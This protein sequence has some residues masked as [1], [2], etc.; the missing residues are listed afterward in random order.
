M[1]RIHVRP[2]KRVKG[3]SRRRIG[4]I[5]IE[6]WGLSPKDFALGVVIHDSNKGLVVKRFDNPDT[7]RDYIFSRTCRGIRFYGHNVQYDLLG[8]MDNPLTFFDKVLFS[9]SQFIMGVKKVTEKDNVTVVDSGNLFKTSLRNIGQS[10]GY[11]KLDTP[12]DFIT[13]KKRKITEQDYLY[14]ERDCGIVYEVVKNFQKWIFREYGCNLGLTIA[15]TALRAFLTRYGIDH[16]VDDKVNDIYRKSYYGGRTEA[17]ILGKTNEALNYY[18]VNSLY[19]YVYRNIRFPD[20]SN[21]RYTSG[22]DNLLRLLKDNTIEGVAHVVAD[23]DLMYPILPMRIDG[24][25]MFPKGRVEGW[26]NFNELR[27]AAENGYQIV[28]SRE[29][30]YSVGIDSPF[31]EYVDRLYELRKHYKETGNR[32]GNVY[33]KYLLNSL[34]GKWGEV[35]EVS[36]WGRWDEPVEGMFFDEVRDGYGYWKDPGKKE[37][38]TNHTIISY[39]SYITSGARCVLYRWMQRCGDVYY[40]DTDSIITPNT[41]VTSDELGDMKLEG[42]CASTEIIGQ[43]HYNMVFTDG[44]KYVKH[45]GIPKRCV[46]I[47]DNTYEYQAF[48]KSKQSFRRGIVAGKGYIARKVV[49]PRRNLK[50]LPLPS[51]NGLIKTVP[52]EVFDNKIKNKF[53]IESVICDNDD[54]HTHGAKSIL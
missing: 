23:C 46:Q 19:P 51:E 6:T 49:Q 39:A 35:R 38:Y 9:K 26:Y 32:M 3:V 42:V 53:Y 24:K 36:E 13:G 7:M 44:T 18:D 1:R 54:I 22:R 10:L 40:C 43:K 27:L 20:P 4:V 33:C 14:C 48:T 17:F 45:K 37:Y 50:R 41:I 30:C 28:E 5:D 11:E 29:I 2:L 21:A 25:L 8:I 15:S 31:R 52:Y 16:I 34:Y 12:D 47:D